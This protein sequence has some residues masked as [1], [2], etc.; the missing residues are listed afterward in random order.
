MGSSFI[1][2]LIFRVVLGL[3]LAVIV[4]RIFFKKSV[5]F[6][7]GVIL[8]VLANILTTSSRLSELGYYNSTV[9]VIIVT[10]F[11]VWALILINSLFKKPLTEFSESVEKLSK[12]DLNVEFNKVSHEDELSK[13]N[14][15]LSIL[16]DNLRSVVSEINQNAENLNNA[17]A[18]INNTAQ[19]LS[20]ISNQQASSTEE[21]AATIEEAVANIE[22][23][24]EN[25]RRT[26]KKSSKVH[27]EVLAVNKKAEGVV[28][29]NNLINDKV[30]IIKEI[31]H[32]TN[33]L[34]LNAAVEAARAGEHG[35]GF[36]VVAGEVRKLAERSREAAEEIVSLSENT[37]NLSNEAGQS[38]SS[39]LPDIEE[40]AKLVEDITSS[41]IEQ[42]A[43]IEQVNS[44]VL[45]LNQ[46]AQQN[47]ATSEEL[48]TTSEE[49]TAQSEQ[50][51]KIIEYFK[52]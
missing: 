23:N 13:L 9:G 25:S 7:I 4:L 29:S 34:A 10:F 16:L 17:S 43:G 14:N 18:E 31:A 52:L 1:S 6:K 19:S 45:Q 39:V 44:A 21:I 3:I 36:A 2:L 26:S 8:T 15:S 41:S 28:S 24:T 35:K 50:L 5:G 30:T 20:T 27:G 37:K 48:A 12:G 38:L 49:L 22:N 33:I 51:K 46:I 42:A 32:Q 40:T 11:T 47:A